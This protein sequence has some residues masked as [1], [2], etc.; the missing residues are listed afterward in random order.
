MGVVLQVLG[1]SPVGKKAGEVLQGV[2]VGVENLVRSSAGEMARSRLKLN[3]KKLKEKWDDLGFKSEY[4]AGT[5]PTKYRRILNTVRGREL[6]D[7]GMPDAEIIE[8]ARTGRVSREQL[9]RADRRGAEI[10]QGLANASR[11]PIGWSSPGGRAFTQF[12]SMAYKQTQITFGYSLREIGHGNL[13]PIVRLIPLAVAAGWS[14]YAL[15]E[16][17]YGRE[18]PVTD[19][20]KLA[21]WLRI[22]SGGI[23]IL[24]KPLSFA[25][26]KGPYGSIGEILEPVIWSDLTKLIDGARTVARELSQP[27]TEGEPIRAARGTL[28]ISPTWRVIERAF[29]LGTAGQ[30]NTIKLGNE[31]LEPYS[32]RK[33]APWSVNSRDFYRLYRR[34]DNQF[35]EG[36]K[37]LQEDLPLPDRYK[38]TPAEY[39]WFLT[40]KAVAGQLD[41]QR[42]EFDYAVK[43]IRDKIPRDASWNRWLKHKS[44]RGAG[45]KA[46]WLKV[47]DLAH[48]ERAFRR[49]ESNVYNLFREDRT[50]T[51]AYL[52]KAG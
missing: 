42:A 17:L 3:A 10:T 38:M 8:A 24:D 22:I 39:S 13:M 19:K 6:R 25:A 26:D 47:Y 16:V 14:S 27:G 33:K 43:L 50:Q 49:L 28:R 15:T 9:R 23:G 20:E 5:A 51:P 34:L 2:T 40:A 11:L 4:Q 37:E 30:G 45:R 7:L 35:K 36:K 29:I 21:K 31:Y 44:G 52:R 46:D 48:D 32:W 1:D 18:P 12:W 41:R